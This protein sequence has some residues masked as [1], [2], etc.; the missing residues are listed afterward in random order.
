MRSGGDPTERIASVLALNPQVAKLDLLMKRLGEVD[1]CGAVLGRVLEANGTL[2]E[3]NLSDNKLGDAAAAPICGALRA[4]RTLATLKIYENGLGA[5]SAEALGGAL[6]VNRGL[7]ALWADR[8]SGLGDAGVARILEGLRASTALTALSLM[9]T[10]MRDAS[11]VVRL[12]EASTTLAELRLD[13][14]GL[15]DPSGALAAA[16]GASA[17]LASVDLETNN[18]SEG[19][20]QAL[21]TAMAGRELKI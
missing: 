10:G 5:A 21:R 11:P 13:G 4:N 20:K 7:A 17:S 15:T 14:N 2:T 12:L 6:A 9:C 18:F 16:M 3:L 1:G 19:E 8:N